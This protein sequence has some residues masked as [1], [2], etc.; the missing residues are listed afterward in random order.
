MSTQEA[1]PP[2]DAI[3]TFRASFSSPCVRKVCAWA[4]TAESSGRYAAAARGVAELKKQIEKSEDGSLERMHLEAD[5]E[6]MQAKASEFSTQAQ[7]AAANCWR[8]HEALQL[9]ER[10]L[11][12]FCNDLSAA[13][14]AGIK[15][16]RKFWAGNGW[17]SPTDEYIL[18]TVAPL[19]ALANFKRDHAE[20]AWQ[21]F[22]AQLAVS[23]AGQKLGEGF[24]PDAITWIIC[25]CAYRD[26]KPA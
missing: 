15:A 17:G 24:Q 5:L 11:E 13:V 20:P 22:R 26:I 21:M 25:G 7:A 1:V 4:R 16:T 12:R 3:S 9:V 23:A 14:E 2:T 19:Q 18:S 6:K 8:T 10:D